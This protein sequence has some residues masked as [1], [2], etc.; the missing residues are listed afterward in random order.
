M[1]GHPATLAGP[2]RPVASGLTA[3][4]PA[5]ARH[6]ALGAVDIGTRERMY[7]MDALDRNRLTPGRY[8]RE[9]EQRFAE[10]HDCG[11]GI[12]CNSGT[13]ALHV[14]LAAL[15][16]SNGWQDG[17]EVLVPALTFIATSNIVL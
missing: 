12:A 1:V 14:A 5:P 7:I 16:E 6:I 3:L 9:F 17:D 11:Y 2:G 15:K 8:V 10:Q 13:S 4:L